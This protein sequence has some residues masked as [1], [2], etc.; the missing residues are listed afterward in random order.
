MVDR[1][2]DARLEPHESFRF[3]WIVE[4]DPLDPQRGP[5]KRTALGRMAHEAASP[6]VAGNG[7]LAVYMGDDDYFEYIY[8]FVSNGRVIAG[9]GAAAKKANDRLLDEG[10]LY[11]ARL[12][13]DGGG[14]WLPLKYDPAGPLNAASGFR[15]Q[16]EVLIQARAAADV[17]GATPMDRP[18]D[19]EI[20]PGNGRIYVSCTRNE[21]RQPASGQREHA[22]RE[23]DWGVDAPNPRGPNLYGHIIEITEDRGDHTGLHFRWDALLMGPT[24]GSTATARTVLG[25]PDNL[26]FDS[27]GRLWVVTD[28]PQPDGGNDGCYVLETSGA[29][30]AAVKRF[31][32]AP[33]G[34]E[35]SGC[36]FAPGDDTLFLGV[37]HPGEGGSVEQPIS[38]WPDGAGQQPRSAVIAIRREDGRPIGT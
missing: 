13:A 7:R 33:R 18:E 28:G 21:Q 30:R 15:S 26:A 32:T 34:A 14:E 36:A 11:V 24:A 38:D 3:G 22:G 19:I 5:V 10:V 8:K 2:F 25:S 23:L 27:S 35:V 16:A 4:I 9:S 29:Q 20:H 1:R 37:Q 17:L 6:V 12:N 31:M